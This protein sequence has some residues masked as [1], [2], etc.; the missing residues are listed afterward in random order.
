MKMGKRSKTPK[1]RGGRVRRAPV[2]ISADGGR[3]R[4]KWNLKKNKDLEDSEK[5]KELRK[6]EGGTRFAKRGRCQN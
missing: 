2:T 4:K 5:Q 6:T 1:A 3:I